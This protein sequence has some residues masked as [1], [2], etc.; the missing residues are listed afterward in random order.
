MSPADILKASL[1]VW[2]AAT[3]LL[4]GYRLLT[5]QINLAG[6][7]TVDGKAFSPSRLQ[8]L[9]VSVTGLVAYAT[10]SLSAHAMVPVQNDLVALLALSHA[11]Y[12]GPKAYRVLVSHSQ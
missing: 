3:G 7:L 1:A 4:L 6:V 11:T 12:I 8:L 9:V 5:G 2:L 10:A